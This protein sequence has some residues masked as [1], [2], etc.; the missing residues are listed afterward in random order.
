ML[1]WGAR[2]NTEVY[3]GITL[4]MIASEDGDMAMVD[5]LLEGGASINDMNREGSAQTL[6]V[7]NNHDSV[8]ERLLAA[9]A[10]V[11][12]DDCGGHTLLMWCQDEEFGALMLDH[13]ADMYQTDGE[14]GDA[15]MW[16]CKRGFTN[17]LSLYKNRG[18]VF[19]TSRNMYTGFMYA[20][21]N[22]HVDIV[23]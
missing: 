15:I 20:C 5:V 13:G 12:I 23:T 4:L 19:T 21:E 11:N 2:V 10:D 7:R 8:I 6:A 22:G 3:N 9:G 17:M 14:G 1:S 18:T 16:A